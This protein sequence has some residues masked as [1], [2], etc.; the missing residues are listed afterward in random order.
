MSLKGKSK[1]QIVDDELSHLY[2]MFM[3]IEMDRVVFATC[4][5]HHAVNIYRSEGFKNGDIL[6]AIDDGLNAKKEIYN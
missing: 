5:M 4:L 1:Y 3:K 2:D 6:R